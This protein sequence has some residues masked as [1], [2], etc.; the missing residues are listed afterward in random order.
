MSKKIYLSPS[1]QNRNMYAYGDTNEMIQ[2]RRIA[3][4]CEKALKR[5]GFEVKNNQSDTM[6]ARVAESNRWDADLHIPIHTNAY[7]SAVGGTRVFYYAK[8]GYGNVAAQHVYDALKGVSPGTADNISAYPE[9]YE[10]RNTTATAVYVEAEF[11]DVPKY[12][13][14]IIEHVEDIGEAICKGVCAY[15]GVTYI[16]TSENVKKPVEND[17]E[18]VTLYRVQVGAYAKKENAE[19]MCERLIKAGYPAY[20]KTY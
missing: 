10:L 2:C 19:A 9:L 7:N 1:D 17:T 16:G 14:W 12:A 6:E 11:H 3:D 20:I 13:K 5:C 4:A 18:G 15:F 8:N